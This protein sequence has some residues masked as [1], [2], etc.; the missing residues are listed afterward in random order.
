MSC[1]IFD[2][3][4]VI[5]LPQSQADQDVIV[6]A[7][8]SLSA[9]SFWRNYWLY[10]ADYDA[11]RLAADAY[12]SKV[13]PNADPRWLVELDV[14]SWLHPNQEMLDL[15]GEVAD[16]DLALLSNSPPE[17]AAAI[18][19]LRWLG[20]VTQRF[21]SCRLGMVKPDKA[22][23]L[24][25]AER[26]GVAPTACTFVD[27]RPANVTGAETAGMTGI[28][29]TDAR[30]LRGQLLLS[31]CARIRLEVPFCAVFMS[32]WA[33]CGRCISDERAVTASTSSSLP[34]LR[35]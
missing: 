34:H 23:Y 16:R 18:D 31:I 29:F 33:G 9:E 32:R 4:G 28:L 26:L 19:G 10:R 17:L 13:A 8:G 2:F 22:I 27:D 11:G 6:A 21:Y 7:A 5:G 35:G 3:A 12:W 30:S 14:A 15:L 25:V 24:A 20:R 1:V